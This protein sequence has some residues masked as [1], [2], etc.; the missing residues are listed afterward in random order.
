VS[1]PRQMLRIS[2]GEHRAG[3]LRACASIERRAKP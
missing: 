3:A 1:H 2:R